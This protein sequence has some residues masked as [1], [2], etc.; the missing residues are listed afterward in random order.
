MNVSASSDAS[1]VVNH[2]DAHLGPRSGRVS[3]RRDDAGTLRATFDSPALGRCGD[4]L[5]GAVARLTAGGPM[6]GGDTARAAGVRA[7]Q[8]TPGLPRGAIPGTCRIVGPSAARASHHRMLLRRLLRARI[9]LVL[10]AG[11]CLRPRCAPRRQNDWR[12][13]TEM[14]DAHYGPTPG[15]TSSGDSRRCGPRSGGSALRDDGQRRGVTV[16]YA[17]GGKSQSAA[18]SCVLAE[19]LRRRCALTAPLSSAWPMAVMNEV[20]A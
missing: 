20:G 7:L 11:I 19:L 18:R 5:P 10:A 13:L 8:N 15:G 2:E 6:F 3:K 4:P 9:V 16:A 14:S 1:E 17:R 12:T